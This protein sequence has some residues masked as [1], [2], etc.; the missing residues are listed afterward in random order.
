[1]RLKAGL[2]DLPFADVFVAVEMRAER[3]FGIVGVD[4]FD[5]VEAEYAV[6]GGYGFFEA[7]GVGDV[8]AGGEEMAGV[9]TIGDRADR[10]RGRPDRG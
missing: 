2:A 10:F 5:E 1:M 4:H 9:E 7:G 8:E 6:G 3:A